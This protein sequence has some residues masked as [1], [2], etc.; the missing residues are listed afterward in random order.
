MNKIVLLYLTVFFQFAVIA[1]DKSISF[2]RGVDIS[3]APQIEDAGGQYRD[4]GKVKDVLD[5]FK[6]YGVNYVRLRL[7]N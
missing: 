3:S 6:E 7:W 1:Q 5:I 4:S 2:I